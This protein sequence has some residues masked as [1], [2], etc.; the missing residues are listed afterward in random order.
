MLR[1]T[2][3][4]G[5]VPAELAC[6][7]CATGLAPPPWLKS[8][9]WLAGSAA[10]GVTLAACYGAPYHG[11]GEDTIGHYHDANGQLIDEAQLAA[12]DEGPGHTPCGC[13]DAAI[14]DRDR[15]RAGSPTAPDPAR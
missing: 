5:W 13:D 11:G 9:A 12:A 6:P 14:A 2:K 10:L 15:D 7:N 1:C 3:C 8:A 4:M